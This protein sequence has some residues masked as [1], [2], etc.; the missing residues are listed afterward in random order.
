[1]FAKELHSVEETTLSRYWPSS[2]IG[3]PRPI[4]GEVPESEFA[5]V[6]SERSATTWQRNWRLFA[7]ATN[8]LQSVLCFAVSGTG[9]TRGSDMV[10]TCRTMIEC[11]NCA[12]QK[13][14]RLP[15]AA[16]A[17]LGLRI[18]WTALGS[19]YLCGRPRNIAS[20]EVDLSCR[21][22]AMVIPPVWKKA[23]LVA[24]AALICSAAVAAEPLIDE[25][26]FK[27]RID[28]LY[29]EVGRLNT[30]HL[31]TGTALDDLAKAAADLC[32]QAVRARLVRASSSVANGEHVVEFDR[33]QTALRAR[34]IAQ[35][36][37]E[38]GVRK[39]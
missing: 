26:E 10:Q 25:N 39:R 22:H 15:T 2:P 12:T 14:P 11:S 29:L 8:T 1:M 36:L 35:E 33:S 27:E 13:P 30:E 5:V 9:K 37:V 21:T 3:S 6:I 34:A 16:F 20:I 23:S 31:T 17:V 28:C 7:E 4:G 19:L 24:A 18:S 38:Y 32:S